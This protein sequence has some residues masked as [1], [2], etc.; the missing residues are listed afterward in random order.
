MEIAKRKKRTRCH[1]F[2]KSNIKYPLKRGDATGKES[3][4]N[5]SSLFLD[6]LCKVKL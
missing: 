1:I 2:E 3:E 6:G 5:R 4:T